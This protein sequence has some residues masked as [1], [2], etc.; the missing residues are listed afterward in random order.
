MKRPRSGVFL[1]IAGLVLLALFSAITTWLI[2]RGRW[3][4]LPPG[5]LRNV[6][7]WAGIAFLAALV[8]WLLLPPSRRSTRGS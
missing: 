2:D 4:E 1:A 6:D 3:P 5:A 8:L 7:L